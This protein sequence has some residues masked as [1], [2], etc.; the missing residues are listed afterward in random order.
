MRCWKQCTNK[1]LLKE[2]GKLGI[3]VKLSGY[4][5]TRAKDGANS[6]VFER[7]FLALSIIIKYK[8]YDIVI[9]IIF[10]EPNQFSK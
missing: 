3:L 7:L 1:N 4:S 6:L 10:Q 2:T 8:K 5:L 9:D